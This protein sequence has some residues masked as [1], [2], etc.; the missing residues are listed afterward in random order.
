MK[1]F[2]ACYKEY[3]LAIAILA[4]LGF[5][6]AL[7]EGIGINA[8]I[9]LFS[10]VIGG[11]NRNDIISQFIE[12]LFS[13]F[14]IEFKLKY[15]LVFIGLLFIFKAVFSVLCEYI[16][17]RIMADY[18]ERTRNKMFDKLL[19]ANWQ[20]LMQQKLGHLQTVLM[21]NVENSAGVLS[22]IGTFIMLLANIFV[23]IIIAINIDL[24]ITL[25]AMILSGIMFFGLLPFIRGLRNLA[26]ELEKTNRIIGHHINENI[27]GIKTVKAMSAVNQVVKDARKI[28]QDLRIIKISTQLR[29]SLVTSVLEPMSIIF[30]LVIFALSYKTPNFNLVAFAVIMY[31]VRQIFSY[32]QSLQKKVLAFSGAIPYFK[33]ISDYE[34]QSED[35]EEK[36]IG[37]EKFK[38]NNSLRFN[39][40]GFSYNNKKVVL[41]DVNFTITR[42]E[43]VGLIGSSGAGKTTVVDLIL[44]LFNPQNGEILLDGKNIDTIDLEEWRKNI[45]Y[46]SQDMFLINNTIESNIKFY[47]ELITDD[48]MIRA[49]TMADI[50]DFIQECPNKF[51]TVIGERGVQLSAGQRQR[52]VIARVL[53]KEPKLLILDEATSALD[54][55]SEVKIQ[56]VIENLKGKLTVFVIAHRLSTV[57]NSDRL[58]VLENGKIVE[59]GVPRELLKDKKTYFYKIYNIRK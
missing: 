58:L 1:I 40:I 21:I 52:I 29:R 2:L 6:S 18:E 24:Y 46:V 32:M 26:Y 10:F 43:M 47:D 34:T 11:G 17:T 36:N 41:A 42:G 5:F 4:V 37:L 33:S 53:A 3:K 12:K 28:F 23:Y 55:E 57:V 39:N 25:Y 20:Y 51:S 19:H 35:N 45:G 50:Y 44:R 31:L 27:F 9:P 38:F 16:R 8:L 59:Q 48:E 22:C 14:N 7:L 13:F 56:K 54:N 30:I 49:A 15:L